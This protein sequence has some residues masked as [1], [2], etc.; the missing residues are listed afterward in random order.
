MRLA[1]LSRDP[2]LYSTYRLREA[3]RQRGHDVQVIDHLRCIMRAGAAGLGLEIDGAVP[4]SFE[5]AIPR[6]GTSVS[7]YGV[8][9]T[10]HL[11]GMG[12]RCVNCADAIALAHD[13]VATLQRVAAAGGPVPETAF[14]YG[15]YDAERMIELTGAAPTVV[16][17]LCSTQGT[18]VILAENDKSAASIVQVFRSKFI[19]VLV[20][21]FVEEARGVDFRAIVIGGQVV[22]A[23]RREGASGEFRSYRY[24]GGRGF[25]V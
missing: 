1:I 12:A 9:L 6:I 24:G 10:R 19:D 16:K 8:A 4:R 7:L 22:A 13:K 11:E 18:G 3:A 25:K 2:T 21:R 23:M 14:G 17:L 5:A 15:S 20:Q